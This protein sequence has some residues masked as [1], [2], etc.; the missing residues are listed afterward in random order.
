M[1]IVNELKKQAGSILSDSKKKEK[2]GDVVEGVLAEV[3]KSVKDEKAKKVL[4]KAIQTVDD[5]TTTKSKKTITKTE[6][7]TSKKSK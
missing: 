2:M 7:K 3:K 4:D 6:K 1:S 5:A